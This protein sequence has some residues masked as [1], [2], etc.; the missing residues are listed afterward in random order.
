MKKQVKMLFILLTIGFSTLSFASN[1]L[2]PAANAT[3]VEGP[4]AQ[5]T[6]WTLVD[7][8][9][10]VSND[11]TVYPNVTLTIEAGVKVKFG[12]DFSLI[13]SGRLYAN[14]A[15]KT[16][17][18]TSNKEQPEGGDWN[19]IPFYGTEKST[20][21]D[22]F[23][24]YAKDGI[25]I[26]NGN[27][28]IE[29]STISRC[30]QNGI[31]A[32]NSELT[33]QNSTIMENE[34][35]GISITGNGQVTIQG[36]SIIANGNGILLTGNETS[37]VNISQ[38]KISANKENGIQ[39]N[40]NNHYDV[41]ILNNNIS[42]N[43]NGFYISSSTSTHITNNSIA[44]N[45]IGIFYDQGT[46]TAHFNDIYGDEMG[47]DVASNATVN[48]E[49]NYW[50]DKSGPLHK[51]LNPQGKGNPVGGNGVN[52]DFIFFLTHPINY[53]NTR[54]TAILWT[55]K[56]LVAPNQTVTLIGTNSYDDGRVDQY[57]FD[58]GDATS[59]GWTTLSLF[60]HN[61]SSTGDYTAKLKVIDDFGVQGDEA[62]T[63]IE[64]R[65]L[66][67][68]KVS[69]TLSNYTVD[70]NEEVLVTVYVSDGSAVENVNVKLF[71]VNGGSFTILSGLTNSSGYFAST[72]T[73]PDVT[74]VTNFRIISRASMVGYADGSDYKYVKVLPPLLVQVT[75]EKTTIKSEAMTTL[76]ANVKSGLGQ[77]IEDALLTLSSDYGNLSATTGVTDVNGSATFI[78][79]APQTLDQI[80]VTIIATAVKTEYAHGYGQTTIIVEPKML[81]IEATADPLIVI[82]EESST[83]TVHVTSGE[84]SIPNATITASS[85]I[86]ETSPTMAE[87]DS[88]GEA[89]LL[90]NAPPVTIREGKVATIVFRATKAGY[91]DGEKQITIPIMP[92]LL[93]IDVTARPSDT[94]SE[95]KVNVTVHVSYEYD[96]SPV[97]EANVT[98]ISE[99]SQGFSPNS[100]L[101]DAN[102]DVNFLFTAPQVN[103]PL[104]IV[105][106]TQASKIGYV[107]GEK[108][109]NIT[110][111]PGTLSVQV[112]TSSTVSSNNTAVVNVYVTCNSTSV[113]NA[114]IT[115][116]ADY[117][118][119]STT[120]GITDSDGSAR[121]VFNA[122]ETAVQLTAMIRANASKNGY[123]SAENQ[124]TITVTQKITPQAEEG[125]PITTILL[126]IIP[127]AIAVVI[128]ILVKL[129]II[130][131]SFKEEEWM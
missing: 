128:V 92:K 35:S 87:T 47:M 111:N 44:Y 36:N 50:G 45:K 107:D 66:T 79:T 97:S 69:I 2:F 39:F 121:F 96:M 76:T 16:I 93:T 56:I 85:D 68:L 81:S 120:R 105:I 98:F 28:E 3:Y 33:V 82:S 7:S 125:W 40:A 10:I 30:S 11:V 57:F 14:G 83:I 65:E 22:C 106:V 67:P 75:S 53:D 63:T 61:Y 94:I 5:D 46:H 80:N 19:A 118:N 31:N 24:A 101:T 9:F 100:G 32:N 119:F 131:V 109:F 4:I 86:G 102:G 59:S 55:D 12:G 90:F 114:S 77:P 1:R 34:G 124:T 99:Y 73:A 64:V 123:V 60:T 130:V 115:I 104:N 88:N 41:I 20:L 8:P 18:F 42:S 126:I 62:V 113:A 117:G 108:M 122:P 15:G 112:I 116:L 27:V 38:N 43:N 51:S 6:V 23:V 52:L 26:E 13:V 72:F 71:S 58:F 17:T 110:V 37:G 21:I 48:A 54:P 74:E 103:E 129:K 91:V 89:T 84:G 78:F 29:S 25:Y 127:V 70:Y 49:H 95:A